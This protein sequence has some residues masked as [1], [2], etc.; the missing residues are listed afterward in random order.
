[1]TRLHTL[2]RRARASSKKRKQLLAKILNHLQP[3]QTVIW[4]KNFL[5]T[6]RTSWPTLTCPRAEKAPCARQEET[7]V[8]ATRAKEE[9]LPR[10]T[11]SQICFSTCLAKRRL[12]QLIILS[13]EIL[14]S[15]KS[16][17]R[18]RTFIIH[19]YKYLANHFTT[20]LMFANSTQTPLNATDFESL[21]RTLKPWVWMQT[22]HTSCRSIEYGDMI[23]TLKKLK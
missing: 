5:P 14:H 20:S 4:A 16:N 19:N 2:L 18:C 1:M 17:H 8:R 15:R 12:L 9:L 13:Q 10:R 21:K 22:Q 7:S 11:S 23:F 6:L 3:Q